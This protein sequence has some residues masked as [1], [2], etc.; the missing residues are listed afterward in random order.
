MADAKP[1]APAVI[2]I[3]TGSEVGLCLEAYEMLKRQGV[4]VRVVSMAS[5]ELFDLQDEAYRDSVLPPEIAARVSVEAGAVI[6]WERYVGT[7]GM[8]IGMRSF[9]ASAPIGDLMAKFG[10]TVEK[11]VGA[12]KAQLAQSR[13]RPL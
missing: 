4:A 9:G 8:K 10:F 13:S 3:G 5:W 6:G 12:A 11:V 2:L 7:S 1:D